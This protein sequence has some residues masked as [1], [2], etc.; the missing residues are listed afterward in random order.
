ME[1]IFIIAF[2]ILLG[3]FLKNRGLLTEKD[4]TAL[5]NIVLQVGF[6]ALIFVSMLRNVHAAELESYLKLTLFILII[7]IFCIILSYF[8]GKALK[9][10]PKSLAAFVLVCACGNTAFIGFPVI[11]G[12]YG[13]DG[14]TR[15]IFCDAVTLIVLIILSTYLASKISRQKVNIFRQIL[16]FPSTIAWVL[17]LILIL[18]G[19]DLSHFPTIA[20]T[21]L[22]MI[23]ALVVPL[24]MLS[25]GISLSPKYLKI[26][27]VPAILVTAL[28]SIIAPVAG[29]FLTNAFQFSELDKKVAVLQAGMPPAMMSAVF[30]ELYDF[31]T[32]LI[33][34]AIFLATGF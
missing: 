18:C 7:C 9:L 28:H 33:S 15:A 16:K 31:D 3:Y 29:L 2:L 21:I 27:L 12:F 22:D 8:I 20:V 17:S 14:F 13:N 34:A 30:S 32:K 23:S 6:P 5:N 26:A 11:T 24:I 25:I 1:A 10:P 4:K 19:I